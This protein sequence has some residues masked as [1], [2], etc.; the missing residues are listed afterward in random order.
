[1]QTAIRSSPRE[2]NTNSTDKSKVE[3]GLPE[4]KS[5]AR[6]EE[7][8]REQGDPRL[9]CDTNCEGPAGKET[10]RQ[11]A[12]PD[13]DVEVGSAHSRPPERETEGADHIT[14]QA[15]ETSP[16]R[17][18]DKNWRTTL[19]AI[20]NKAQKE[21]KYRFGGL[22]QL[23]NKE[24]LRECFHLLRKS[25]APGVDGVTAQEYEKELE[26]NLD[27]LVDRLKR[28][29]YHAKL[30]RRKYIPKGDGKMRPLGIP[31][32]ED[33]L[34]QLVATEILSAIYEGVFLDC[35]YG[36][37][38][39]RGPQ[40]A[41]REMTQALQFGGYHFIVEADIKRFFENIQHQWMIRMLEER[42]QDGAML[43]LISKWLKAGIME[44][45][46]SVVN[47]IT[48]TPQGGIISPI[49]ANVYLHYVLDLWFEKRVKRNDQRSRRLFRYADDFVALF[50]HRYEAEAFHRDL[51]ERLRKFGLEVAPDKTQQIRFGRS[52]GD[53]N[54]RFDFLGIEFS[55]GKSRK[56]PPT[57]KRR[58]ARKKLRNSI[59]AF[60]DWIRK[61]RSKKLKELMELL[62][63]KLTGYW[64][65]FGLIGNNQSMNHYWWEVQRR[66]FK[67]LNRRSQRKSY[68]WSC[69]NRMIRRFEIPRPRRVEKT[70]E[71][72]RQM[73]AEAQRLSSEAGSKKRSSILYEYFGLEPV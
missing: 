48:G 5:A 29:A 58:T 38:P 33:K 69:F 55:W 40:R 13:G 12:E 23:I 71:E 44:E 25:A 61:N 21:P 59:R 52:G 39:G 43:R 51:I 14:Q 67:W 49:L 24:S 50:K 34:V 9:S 26:K 57:I 37:R 1:M 53:Y 8:I 17:T 73:Q 64:N 62:K 46:G 70:P 4:S 47:P 7:C 20:T 66:L 60:D 31:A 28:K 22:Y 30:V 54:G 42:I 16:V 56:G 11:G 19:F 3:G 27:N 6:L 15:E 72:I 41:I 68:T 2:A 65:Y 35:S 45:D 32:L 63:A 18:T 10:Q 36:C